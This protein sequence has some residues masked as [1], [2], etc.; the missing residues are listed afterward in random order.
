M[1]VRRL[2]ATRPSIAA[3]QATSTGSSLATA[4]ATASWIFSSASGA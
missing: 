3:A 2:K 4:A 1:T